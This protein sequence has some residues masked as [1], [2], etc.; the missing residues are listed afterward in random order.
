M[1]TGSGTIPFFDGRADAVGQR[2][3]GHVDHQVELRAAQM[4]D[5][6]G[7]LVAQSISFSAMARTV[8]GITAMAE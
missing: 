7:K 3:A 4:A 5:A 8:S 6:L 2:D 1:A